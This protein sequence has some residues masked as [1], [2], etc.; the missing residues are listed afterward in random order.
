MCDDRSLALIRA[1]TEVP[2][3]AAM[4]PR[5]SPETTVWVPPE[6]DEADGAVLDELELR[7]KDRIW[8]G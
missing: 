5:V 7:E 8:P 6:V 3:C 2:F 4:R 1:D